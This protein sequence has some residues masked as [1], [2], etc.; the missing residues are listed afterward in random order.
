LAFLEGNRASPHFGKRGCHG[1]S[2]SLRPETHAGRKTRR[3]LGTR[4]AVGW[5][6][7]CLE[8]YAGRRY[9]DHSD[10]DAAC[11]AAV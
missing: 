6:A 5:G 2:E 10:P 8:P 3:I 11:L 4:A 7:V 1:F 9:D